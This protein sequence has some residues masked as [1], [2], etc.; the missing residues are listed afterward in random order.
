MKHKVIKQGVDAQEALGKGAE[1]LTTAIKSTIGPFGQNWYIKGGTQLTN[2]GKKIASDFVLENE[3]ENQGMSIIRSAGLKTEAE[4]QDASSTAMVLAGAIRKEAS[5]YLGNSKGVMARMAT[6]EIIETVEKEREEITKKL[7]E[8]AVPVTSREQ[9]IESA[10]VSTEDKE[11]AELIGGTQWDLGP[12]GIILAEETAEPTSSIERVRGLIF[13]NGFGTSSLMNN[14]EKQCLEVSEAKVIMTNHTLKDLKPLEKVL[15]QLVSSKKKT[16][17]I[18]ARAFT[19]EAIDVCLKNI[20]G[21]DVKIYPINAPYVNQAEIM[22]DLAASIGG[23]FYDA[24]GS[25]LED[26]QLSDV[27]YAE[28]IVARRYDAVFTG[29]MDEKSEERV[30]KRVNDLKLKLNQEVSEFEKRNLEAR[31]AQLTNGFALLKIGAKTEK[32]R[33]RK[34]DKADDAVGAVRHALKEGVVPGAGLAFKLI[35][36]NLPDTYILKKPLQ[37]IHEQIVASAPK[38]W[39][40]AEWVKDPVKVMR[41][42]LKYACSEGASCATSGGVCL[43]KNPKPRLMQEVASNEN[44]E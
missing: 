23:T 31:I 32:E 37:V 15:N 34:K 43:D 41:V 44:E 3:V 40:V 14:Q 38:D 22:K 2:D 4:V 26:M 20:N 11:L 39:T 30:S 27:G 6:S 18:V 5:K 42:A 29:K 10:L 9:L 21:N 1:F 13:D 33:G 19:Q 28:R 36:D 12:E 7:T 8:M 25:D 17:V 16:I 24:E 35:A